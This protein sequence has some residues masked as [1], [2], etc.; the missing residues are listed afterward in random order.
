MEASLLTLEHDGVV[1]SSLLDVFRRHRFTDFF[2]IYERPSLT[3]RSL[4]Q[5]WSLTYIYM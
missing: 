4:E 5:E 2:A 1:G 3:P